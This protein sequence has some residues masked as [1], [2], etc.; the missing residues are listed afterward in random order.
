MASV[1]ISQRRPSRALKPAKRDDHAIRP[2]DVDATKRRLIDAVGAI[3]A[4]DGFSRL[5][6]NAIAHEAATDKALI[7]RYFGGLPELLGAYAESA[8][9]WPTVDEMAGGSLAGLAA[10][11]VRERWERALHHYI[12]ELRRRPLTQ[13]ILAWELSE[14][15]EVTARLEAVRERRGLELSQVLARDLPAS[16]DVA[17]LAGVFA[18]AIHYLLLR[19]RKIRMF[20]GID[21]QS[22]HGWARL[23]A[24]A[25]AMVRSTLESNMR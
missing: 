16:V 18:S 5:G 2:R 24:V 25:Q 14:R 19:A 13:E 3:L 11:P 8:S 1:K 23:E 12:V 9:F 4:R 21:L 10:R 7:Y 20:N 17:A 15:N 22:E 6:V